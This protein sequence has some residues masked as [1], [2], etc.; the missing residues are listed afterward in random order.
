MI[1]T[2]VIDKE[3]T[4]DLTGVARIDSI[5]Q[6]KLKELTQIRF[7]INQEWL[8]HEFGQFLVEND[9]LG[10]FGMIN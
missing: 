8:D 4:L 6:K 7:M 9:L 5:A 2:K 3:K 1:Q 10:T